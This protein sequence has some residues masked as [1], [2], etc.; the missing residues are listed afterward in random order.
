MIELSG[1]SDVADLPADKTV[2]WGAA[3]QTLS[4][5]DRPH[6]SQSRDGV[7]VLDLADQADAIQQAFAR[8]SQKAIEEAA[9]K[10]AY[11]SRREPAREEAPARLRAE[12]RR[13]TGE[14]A[15]P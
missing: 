15:T 1:S 12:M 3:V 9:R 7:R 13:R 14:G 6:P 5:F 4:R 8:W 10:G 11:R 2:P